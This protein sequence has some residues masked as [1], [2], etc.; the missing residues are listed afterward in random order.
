MHKDYEKRKT[1]DILS[2]LPIPAA[3]QTRPIKE[4]QKTNKRESTVVF[5]NI[6]KY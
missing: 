6:L 4:T 3:N 1:D 5:E 2:N